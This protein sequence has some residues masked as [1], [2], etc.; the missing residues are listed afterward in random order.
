MNYHRPLDFDEEDVDEPIVVQVDD[1]GTAADEGLET[2]DEWQEQ[3][4][5]PEPQVAQQVGL[6][7]RMARQ[8]KPVLR[9]IDTCACV[10]EADRQIIKVNRPIG[11]MCEVHK[12]I[13]R[14]DCS[15]CRTK[16]RGG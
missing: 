13:A 4:Q 7:R 10:E 6:P 8:P 12:Q 16:Y 9:Y 11:S 5:Q 2:D 3:P 14:P 15:Q 1:M